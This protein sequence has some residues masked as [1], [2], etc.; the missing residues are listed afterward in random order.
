MLAGIGGRTVEEAKQRMTYA[1]FRDWLRYREKV[2]PLNHLQRL[3]YA[4]AMLASVVNRS[5]GGRA[6]PS[7]FIPDYDQSPATPE[8]F[9][10]ILTGG[11]R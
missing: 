4:A 11:K 9:M 8:D 1:E 5:A 3:D 6:E 7:D 2:G 10:R